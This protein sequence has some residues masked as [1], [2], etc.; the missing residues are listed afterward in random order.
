MVEVRAGPAVQQPA[1]QVE[2]TVAGPDIQQRILDQV[3]LFLLWLFFPRSGFQLES[4]MAKLTVQERELAN[5]KTALGD[6]KARI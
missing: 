2:V 1:Q 5:I 4:V 3:E 6:I